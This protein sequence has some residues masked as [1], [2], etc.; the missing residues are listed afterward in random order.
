LIL[1]STARQAY[2]A[3]T[4]C[5]GLSFLHLLTGDEPYEVLMEK[6]KCP[7][8]L[9]EQLSKY[10]C[11]FNNFDVNDP[12]Y[13]ICDLVRSLEYGEEDTEVPGMVLFDTIYRYV[14]LFGGAEDFLASSPFVDNP[15]W[16]AIVDALGL[17]VN[18]QVEMERNLVSKKKGRGRPKRN[19]SPTARMESI[20]TYQSDFCRWSIH[21]GT[22]PIMVHVQNRLNQ[23]GEG[24]WRLLDKLTHFDPARR[25]K[26]HEAILN[27]IFYSLRMNGLSVENT[28]SSSSLF[29][30]SFTTY[31]RSVDEG[32]TDALPLL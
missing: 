21:T 19:D 18:E 5:M 14:V 22:H 2:S 32:G 12:Y 25:C 15:V 28:E 9:A 31:K 13:L 27:P 29:H 4:F 10:W 3:D 24:S 11:D 6:L 17:D 23:L 26:M 1:G 20:T 8:Y 30:T 7:R 16:M